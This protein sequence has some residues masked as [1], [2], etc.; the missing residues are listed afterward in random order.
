LKKNYRLF[1]A[2]N[3]GV[4][5]PKLLKNNGS[6]IL[7]DMPTFFTAAGKKKIQK[8]YSISTM[9]SLRRRKGSVQG[10]LKKA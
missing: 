6:E 3:E 1:F 4:S 8:I 10:G 2:R 5:F 7:H 9:T